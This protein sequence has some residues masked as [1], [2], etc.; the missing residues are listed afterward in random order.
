MDDERGFATAQLDRLLGFFNRV[1]AKAAFV[2]AIDVAL[3]GTLALNIPV[4]DPISV[5]T[6]FAVLAAIPLAV[7]VV[8][9]FAT[10]FPHL[11]N[12]R[13][14]LIYFG[15]IA[16]L[17]ADEYIRRTR[18]LTNEQLVE[19]LLCQ[20]W[21]NAEILKIKFER[22]E[23]AFK[24]TGAALPLWMIFLIITTAQTGQLPDFTGG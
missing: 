19:E 8:T 11:K 15:D 22:S 17:S 18:A 4:A 23:R 21:R 10:F 9:L 14:G 6:L 2:F 24:W 1:E 3:L 5:P 7:S 13:P 12:G 20:V 16:K